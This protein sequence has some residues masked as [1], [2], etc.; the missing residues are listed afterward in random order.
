MSTPHTGSAITNRLLAALPAVERTQLT[1]HMEYVALEFKQVLYRPNEQIPYVYFPIN[2]VN[3]LIVTM[4][5]GRAVEVGTVGNEG[6]VGLPVF[7]GAPMTTGLAISQIPGDA[8][9]MSSESFDKEVMRLDGALYRLLHL[10]TQA[11]FVQTA[12]GAACNRLHSIEQRFC[13]W[14]LMTHDR[15][16]WDTFPLTQEFLSQML[17]IRRAGVSIVAAAIK[18]AGLIHYERGM[19]TVLDRA[20][21]E[22]TTCECYEVIQSEY[23]RVFVSCSN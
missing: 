18:Q 13:R 14:L 22:A 16:G 17:G 5:D 4:T 12:Q 11:M 9:R 20:G 21:L 10:Y 2:N 6:M 23:D 8:L 15:V 1:Q 3:S 19:M 7:L